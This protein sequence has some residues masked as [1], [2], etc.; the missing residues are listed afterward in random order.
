MLDICACSIGNKTDF[1]IE[2]KLNQVDPYIMGNV[3]MWINGKY[4]GYFDEEVMITAFQVALNNTVARLNELRNEQFETKHIKDIVT[5]ICRDIDENGKYILSLGESFDDFVIYV[6]C[7]NNKVYFI[8]QLIENPFFDY[9]NYNKG[10]QCEA[11]SNE[12]FI[13]VIALLNEKLADFTA[14]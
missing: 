12:I 8:W 9:L 2:Y 7:K 1:A 13:Q 4:V 6:F 10:L 5:L 3:C 11:I 14:R